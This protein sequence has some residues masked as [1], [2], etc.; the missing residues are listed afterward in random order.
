MSVENCESAHVSARP[1]RTGKWDKHELRAKRQSMG[2]LGSLKLNGWKGFVRAAV[3]LWP[4]TFLV[5]PNGAGKSSLLEA[6][7]LVSHLGRRGSLREDLR[8]WLRGW[9]DGVM[10]RSPSRSTPG[11]AEIEFEWRRATYRLVLT[12]DEQP[13]IKSEHL[14][15]AGKRYIW[16]EGRIRKFSGD[17]RGRALRI[18]DPMESALGLYA[19][20]PK[21][22]RGAE[23]MLDLLKGIEIYALDA[24]FLR[25]TAVDTR[26]IPYARKGPGLVSGLVDLKRD[27]AAF[28]EV[29][30]AVRAVQ[31]DLKRILVTRK[32]RSVLF[33]Y[34]DGRQTQLDEESDGVVRAVGMFLVRYR[35]DCPGILGFDEPENGFHLSRQLDVIQRLAPAKRTTLPSPQLMLLASHSP[36]LVKKA[37]T[38]LKGEMGVVTLWRSRNGT[39]TTS[40]WS[41]D[42]LGDQENFDLLLSEGFES[43]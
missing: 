34:V 43:R 38:L 37:A 25:G 14:E 3:P 20:S 9:P 11:E 18:E 41:G 26:P 10:T 39:I 32:P 8:P 21:H 5:G 12:N 30:D 1:L 2:Q 4:V 22:R 15:I 31:P 23:G 28:S 24:D 7:A 35:R 6:L 27:E 17:T 42:E 16:T 29:E 19:L 40:T 13:E 33:E 36:A